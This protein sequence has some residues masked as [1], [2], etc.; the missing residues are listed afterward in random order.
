MIN[1]RQLRTEHAAALLLAL[2]PLVYFLPATAGRLVLCPD[3][4]II[5]NLPLRVAAAQ[6]MRDGH[7]PLWNPYIFGGMPL[8]GAAQAGVLMPL[9]WFFLVFPPKLA[10][11]LSVFLTYALAGLGAYLYARRTGANLSGALVTGFGWQWS[12]FLVAQIGHTNIIQTACLLPWLLWAIDGYGAGQEGRGRRWRAALVA[13]VV[14]LQAFAGHQQTLVYGLLLA[15]AY[16]LRMAW[17][18]VEAGERRRYFYALTMLAAGLA[19][20]AVQILPTLEMMRNS[21]RAEASYE[22]FTS[23]SMPPVFLLSFL[24]PYVVGGGDGQLFRAP[25]TG[26]AFYGEYIGYVGIG[27][28]ALAVLAPLL[29]RDER[30]K[31]WTVAALVCLALAL[32]GFWPFELYRLVYYVPVLNLFRV[33][34]RHLMEVDFALAV[35]AGRAVTAIASSERRGRA[36]TLV[37]LV[38]ASVFA[39]TCL[40]V[41]AWRPESFRLARQAPVTIL[42]APELFLPIVVAALGVSVLWRFARGRKGA[43]AWLLA[44]VV[45][46]LALWGQSSGWR[47]SSPAHDH[48][49]WQKP[50]VVEFLQQS[51]REKGDAF[52]ILTTPAPFVADAAQGTSAARPA[53]DKL[54]LPA[55]PDIYMMHGIENA[56]GYDGFGLAR[57]SRLAGNMKLWG[58]LEDP[59]QSLR[60]ESRAFDVLGVRYLVTPS[61]KASEAKAEPG[62]KTGGQD[63]QTT[64]QKRLL[65]ADEK[66]GAYLFAPQDFGLP[67]LEGGAGLSFDVPGV[68]TK[69]VALITNLSWSAS[70]PDG[71][72]VGRLRLRT[73]E[74]A[75]LKFP[76]R[77]GVDTAEWAHDREAAHGR[78]QHKRARVATS[79]KLDD[80]TGNYEGHSYLTSFE[81]PSK[82]SIVGGQIES[83]RLAEAPK[84]G[85]GVQRVSLIDEPNGETLALT[86]ELL[87][88]TSPTGE[89]A[90]GSSDSRWRRAAEAGDVTVYENLRA[91]PRA[92]LATDAQVVSDDAALE[93]IRTGKLPNGDA[94]N[95]RRTAL[96]SAPLALDNPGGAGAQDAARAEI[97]RYEPN[98]IDIRTSSDAPS[99]L[100]LGDNHYPGWRATLDGRKVE[101]LRVNYNLRGVLLP[102]GAH[103]V[104]FTY[105]PKSALL[106]LLLSLL[107]AAGLV[108]WA[109]GERG[110]REKGKG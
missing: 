99:V 90:Q 67:Y 65:R 21:L 83:A 91:L 70:V 23:F 75:E 53:P 1:L 42:R 72:T 48:A 88:E 71:A 56:A 4:G 32:G 84:L 62:T 10:M 86:R 11:N 30:T 33:P 6:M 73:S 66:L 96:L 58:E 108:V 36:T 101:T 87:K 100:I 35:L 34:A 15:S 76:L 79:S 92:W 77:A 82:V 52:R 61:P 3:D 7:L 26:P 68:Q 5:F 41:T 110:K 57:Y 8:F 93:A 40:A 109:K 80:P 22:F 17:L 14:A 106:G 39:L 78:I 95:S 63:E 107:T 2:A 69:R 44:F 43:S 94:W 55:H 37:L 102:P 59:E 98:R 45:A 105:R 16:A 49:L 46:D 27:L 104:R 51:R 60:G 12:G 50:P 54:I 9:N 85:L 31:F 24:A 81:L 29:K 47:V 64:A 19:L 20:A 18:A 74:G 97:E 25:Y 89:P 28:L 13:L 38:G 103:H